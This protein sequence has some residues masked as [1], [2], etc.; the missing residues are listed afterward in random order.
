MAEEKVPGH[1][2]FWGA[3][4]D[5]EQLAEIFSIAEIFVLPRWVGLAIVHAFTFGLPIISQRG[6]HPP[7]IQ[8]LH[9]GENGF[10]VE[11][12]DTVAMAER[13]CRLLNDTA[14]HS[15]MSRAALSTIH[16]EANVH[17][18]LRGMAAAIGVKERNGAA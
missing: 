5:E 7:E 14:L 11:Q 10:F 16:T 8:Y 1:V 17:I 18:M 4:Y 12:G 6:Y 3:L 13:I 9:D 2:L 15:Q